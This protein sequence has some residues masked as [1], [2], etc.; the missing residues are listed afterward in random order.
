MKNFLSIW[1]ILL[2]MVL[3][4]NA[5]ETKML[6]EQIQPIAERSL[7][8]FSALITK[9]NY[10]Q[11]GFTSPKEIHF[12]SLGTPIEDYMVRLDML[13][14]YKPGSN[15]NRL[16]MKINQY[17]YPVLTKNKVRSSITISKIKD[18]WKTVSFG[19]SNFM[20]LVSK[21]IKN[22]SNITGLNISSYFIVRIPA[23]NLFFVGYRKDRNLWLVPL[24]DDSRLKFKAGVSIKAEKVFSKILPAAK[25][26]SGLPS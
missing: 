18:Q 8:S 23:L 24:L 14:E 13:K 3:Q 4:S 9:K 21:T 6:I 2:I 11:M 22:N 19:D 17:I 25:A 7:K 26:H 20:K 16:L 1:V 5:Q 15:P 12:A 10:I